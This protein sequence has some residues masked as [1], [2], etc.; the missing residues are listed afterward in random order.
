MTKLT[1]EGL[2][3]LIESRDYLTHKTLTVCVLTM[4]HGAVVTGES[5]VIDPAN[6]DATI[7][8]DMAYR[9]ALSKLWQLE[10]YAT[11]R[12]AAR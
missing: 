10:G 4:K 6:Y 7:G 1:A 3:A 8:R 12:E 5:N 2:E 11:K 9:D